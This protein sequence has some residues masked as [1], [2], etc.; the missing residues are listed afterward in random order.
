MRVQLQAA[1]PLEAEVAT[2]GGAYRFCQQ[3]VDLL[4]VEAEVRVAEAVRVNI[5][6]ARQFVQR[7]AGGLEV[8]TQQQKI[9]GR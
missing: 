7:G 1:S 9:A 5:R 2:S 4:R 8:V 6:G 3:A